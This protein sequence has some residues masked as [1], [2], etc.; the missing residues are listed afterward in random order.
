M[1]FLKALLGHRNDEAIAEWFDAPQTPSAMQTYLNRR[2]RALALQPK[3]LGITDRSDNAALAFLMEIGTA[4]VHN[5]T[6]VA[7]ADGSTSLYLSN[8]E[9]VFGGGKHEAVR[10][11]SRDLIVQA[12]GYADHMLIEAGEHPLPAQGRVRFGLVR[13]D[14]VLVAEA[15][16]TALK[17]DQH[18]LGA[19]F[20]AACQLLAKVTEHAPGSRAPDSHASDSQ[21]A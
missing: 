20:L 6:L 18:P 1:N 2:S 15:S 3:D 17:E 9:G 4:G 19:L 13:E 16:Q 10:E 12:T 5:V 8:G 11:E 7:V 21:A 14:G